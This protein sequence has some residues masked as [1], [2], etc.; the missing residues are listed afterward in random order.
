MKTARPPAAE[1]GRLNW[2]T[3]VAY[4][5]VNQYLIHLCLTGFRGSIVLRGILLSFVFRD[6]RQKTNYPV[7]PVDPV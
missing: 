7:Y 4:S 2:A 6:E 1:E 5:V 3:R